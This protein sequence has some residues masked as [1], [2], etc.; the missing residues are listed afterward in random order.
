V[1]AIMLF[2]IYQYFISIANKQDK[3]KFQ[4]IK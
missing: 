1:L 4:K 3:K 2:Y